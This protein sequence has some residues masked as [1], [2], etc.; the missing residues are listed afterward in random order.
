MGRML[1]SSSIDAAD[2]RG[3]GEETPGAV[4]SGEEQRLPGLKPSKQRRCQPLT[5]PQMRAKAT[6]L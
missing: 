4:A 5:R 2:S 3:P 1:G 6:A